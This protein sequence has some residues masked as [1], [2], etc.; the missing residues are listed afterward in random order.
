MAP[1][2]HAGGG[3]SCGELSGLR[4]HGE[5]EA[6]LRAR[7]LSFHNSEGCRP[8]WLEREDPTFQVIRQSSRAQLLEDPVLMPR[9]IVPGRNQ[10]NKVVMWEKSL[11]QPH[12]ETHSQS[13]SCEVP[14]LPVGRHP[15]GEPQPF[16][17]DRHG[18]TAS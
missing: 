5:G 3:A 9:S 17:E 15:D 8:L 7:P 4:R 11:D 12:V 18:N 6:A 16:R 1:A 2:T 14:R 13:T 10:I